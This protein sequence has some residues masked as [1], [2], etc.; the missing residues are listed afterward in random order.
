MKDRLE[1]TFFTDTLPPVVKRSSSFDNVSVA[2]TGVRWR[3]E[4]CSS[5]QEI[6]LSEFSVMS[7][8]IYWCG[9][10]WSA[11][12]GRLG[13]C[14]KWSMTR[15]YQL[16]ISG[17]YV[18]GENPRMHYRRWDAGTLLSHLVVEGPC[19]DVV[20][21]GHFVEMVDQSRYLTPCSNIHFEDFILIWI[22]GVHSKPGYPTL[23]CV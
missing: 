8:W 22:L 12:G 17:Q 20:S 23:T 18:Q 7:T 5:K 1:G 19:K 15:E 21:R 13:A 16:Q 10:P 6:N 9:V 14:P 4:R 2:V 3:K 11:S